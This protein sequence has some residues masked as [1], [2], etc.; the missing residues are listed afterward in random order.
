MDS[1]SIKKITGIAVIDA[2]VKE[3]MKLG[4][5]TGSTAIEAIHRLAE[6]IREGKIKQ[7]FIVPTS[8]QTELEC[9][10]YRIPLYSLND[11]EIDGHLDL[12]I[13]GADE[14]DPHWQLIKGGGGAMVIEKIIA[15]YSER[16]AIIVDDSKIVQGLG[17]KF[18]VPVEVYY[19]A[20]SAVTRVF[21]QLGARVVVREGVKLIGPVIT[22]HG[23]IIAD[24]YFEKGF[25][26]VQMEQT[27]NSIPGAMGNGIFTMQVTDLFIGKSDGSVEHRT[28]QNRI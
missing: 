27:L 4:M 3:G 23:N 8:L 1:K 22:R 14:V 17:Y 13:D 16:Y 25:D 6:I 24:L 28:N 21:E 19:P 12:T 18:P 11:P 2:M 10:K 15:Q 9:R 26:P 7:I 5:G 20:L